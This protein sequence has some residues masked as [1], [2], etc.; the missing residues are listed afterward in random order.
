MQKLF[1]YSFLIFQ[2]NPFQIYIFHRLQFC[3]AQ[4]LTLN[5]E[6][7]LFR[8]S[9]NCIMRFLRGWMNEQ[10]K[11]VV[12][13]TS[14]RCFVFSTF[15][16]KLSVKISKFSPNDSLPNNIHISFRAFLELCAS[17]VCWYYLKCEKTK[18]AKQKIISPPQS[19]AWKNI[20]STSFTLSNWKIV[21][22]DEPQKQNVNK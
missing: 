10:D 12:G 18:T 17:D 20:P 13:K 3:F 1:A 22:N 14:S 2:Q 5:M 4:L 7:C 11:E 6:C 21:S 15:N 19:S 9:F 16:E 8:I